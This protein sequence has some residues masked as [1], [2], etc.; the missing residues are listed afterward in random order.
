MNSGTPQACPGTR[1]S[2]GTGE[3]RPSTTPHGRAE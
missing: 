2:R 3:D 1:G